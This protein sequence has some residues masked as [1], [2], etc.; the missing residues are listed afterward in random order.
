LYDDR[1]GNGGEIYSRLGTRL[2]TW[3]S[4]QTSAGQL[5]DTDLRLRPNGD[6]GL[7]VSSL[8]AFRRYQM[9]SAWMWEHQALT[10]A[11]FSAGDAEV[12]AGF[13]RIRIDVLAQSRDLSVL[14]AE[15]LA[16]RQKMFDAHGTKAA[17]RPADP[18]AA[19]FDLKHDRG[20]L[21][22]V[23]FMVQFLVLGYAHR[24]SALTA[25]LGNIALLKIASEFDLIPP[26]LADDVRNA[27]RE[28]RRLQ[29]QLRLNGASL[30]VPLQQVLP[31]VAAVRALWTLVFESMQTTE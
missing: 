10:R 4:A 5:F 9:E 17:S 24:H 26:G 13:E 25:N 20:G 8:D 21:V 22:D 31:R 11:R 12:G 19:E 30:R 15:V 27:Y 14:R 28:Y 23:E 2:N 7:M 16:M 18:R 6:S 1:A 3:L 29:H